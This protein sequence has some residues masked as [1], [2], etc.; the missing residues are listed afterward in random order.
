[1]TTK[2][3]ELQVQISCTTPKKIE[4]YSQD[5]IDDV[6]SIFFRFPTLLSLL[7]FLARSCRPLARVSTPPVADGVN[8]LAITGF[9]QIH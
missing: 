4:P 2:I 9:T 7:G 6:R 3:L 8:S 1:M 5:V